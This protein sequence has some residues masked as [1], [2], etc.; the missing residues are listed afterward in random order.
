MEFKVEYAEGYEDPWLVIA[1]EGWFFPMPTEQK[2]QNLCETLKELFKPKKPTTIAEYYTEWEKAITE[3]SNK[4]ERLT[5]VKEEYNQKE[6]DIVFLNKENVDFKELY[7]STSEKVR[8]QHAALKLQKL[9]NEKTDLE[10]SIDYLK[11]RIDFIKSIV[12]AKLFTVYG[13]GE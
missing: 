3:L 9:A 5:K 7:G 10:L 2:A 11:R 8:K 4:E 1:E 13:V 6:F 12:K